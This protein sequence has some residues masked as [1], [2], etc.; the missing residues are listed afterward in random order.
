MFVHFFSERLSDNMDGKLLGINVTDKESG[1]LTVN[2]GTIRYKNGEIRFTMDIRTPITADMESIY[3]NLSLVLFEYGLEISDH[4]SSPPLYVDKNSR[5]IQSLL[6][7]YHIIAHQ[8]GE[9]IAIGGGT[10]AKSFAN[11]VAFGPAFPGEDNQIH[12]PEEHIRVQSLISSIV[13]SMIAISELA[14]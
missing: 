4:H 14:N 7:A 2:V 8:E 12:Q 9:P 3:K 13:I 5:L 6:K 11:M 1:S 10:Y